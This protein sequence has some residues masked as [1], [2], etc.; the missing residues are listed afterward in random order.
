MNERTARLGSDPL[1]GLP[2]LKRGVTVRN[3]RKSSSNR[4][5]SFFL[6][7]ARRQACRSETS[8]RWLLE[9]GPSR[10]GDRPRGTS[11]RRERGDTESCS[12]NR[13]VRSSDWTVASFV[14]IVTETYTQ[15]PP[16]PRS[17]RQMRIRTRLPR[18][19]RPSDC[20]SAHLPIPPGE[21]PVQLSNEKRF[22]VLAP[23]RSTIGC[24]YRPALK[25]VSDRSPPSV[26]RAP[27]F[28]SAFPLRS[29]DI[30]RFVA[31][32]V[33]ASATMRP[34]RGGSEGG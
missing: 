28:R 1:C 20:L 30:V 23:W 18:R 25:A 26:Y 16:P 32:S 33:S 15:P 6:Y 34:E 4:H 21:R 10:G 8:K 17:A 7:A 14:R 11:G 29:P 3:L 24:R 27:R 31:A 5:G 13:T 2:D 19:P 9:I 22:F 12:G